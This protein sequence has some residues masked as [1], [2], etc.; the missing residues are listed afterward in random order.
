MFDHPAASAR[1]RPS[2]AES[3]DVP[4]GKRA[5][6]ATARLTRWGIGI[7]TV[8]LL[9]A[10]GPRWACAQLVGRDLP[11]TAY[12]AA[13]SLFYDGE[14]EDALDVFEQQLRGAM[15]VGSSRWIDSICY[16]TMI[17]EC[18]YRMGRF[19]Q[20]LASY[21]A[22]AQLMLAYRDWV[23]H[24]QY[25]PQIQP[26]SLGSTNRR[27][28]W[29]NRTRASVFGEFPDRMGIN[30]GQ[31]IISREQIIRQGGGVVTN[32]HTLVVDV[33]EVMRCS[34]LAIRRRNELLGPLAPHDEVTK[35]L[36][37]YYSSRPGLPNH[38][39][40]CWMDVHLGMALLGAG[41]DSEAVSTLTRGTLAA[42]RFEHPLSGQALLA[43]GNLAMERGDYKSAIVF[44][45]EASIDSVVYPDPGLTEEA[46]QRAA[47]AYMLANPGKTYPALGPA[48]D[49]AKRQRYTTMYASLSLAAADNALQNGDV[50]SASRF[51]SQAQSALARRTAWNSRLGARHQYLS[52]VLAYRTGRYTDGESA[53][54]AALGYMSHG[55]LWLYHLK[56]LQSAYA[57]GQINLRGPIT[58]RAA[59][60]LYARLL[61]TPNG[62]DWDLDPLE[63]LSIAVTPHL[64]AY[65]QWFLIALERKSFEEAIEISDYGRQHR[66][67]TTL[68]LGGRLFSLRRLLESDPATL[69]PTAQQQ[70]Q[71]LLTRYPDYAKL[72][73]QAKALR[74]SLAGVSPVPQSETEA[75]RLLAVLGQLATVGAQQELIIRQMSIERNA[76]ASLFPL[77]VPT[78]EIQARIPEGTAVLAFYQVG[79]DMYGVLMNRTRY[80]TWRVPTT[81]YFARE[82]AALETAMGLIDAN[83]EMN[84]EDLQKSDWK[85]AAKRAAQV[86]LRDSPLDPADEFPELVIVPDGLLWY[87]PFEALPTTAEDDAL[88]WIALHQIRYAPTVSSAV[89]FGRPLPTTGTTGVILGK[90]HP[91]EEAEAPQFAFEKLAA[92]SPQT[93]AVTQEPRTVPSPVLASLF[94]RLIVWDDLQNLDQGVYGWIPAPFSRTPNGNTLDHWLELPWGRPAMMILPG[95]H[96]PAESGLRRLPASLPPGRDMFLSTCALMAGGTQSIVLSRWRNGGRTTV[97][98]IAE[99]LKQQPDMTPSEAFQRSV[100]VAADLPVDPQAEPRVRADPKDPPI[101][102]DHPFFWASLMLLDSGVPPQKE[103]AVPEQ[104]PEMRPAPQGPVNPRP[105]PAAPAVQPQ[106]DGEQV[107]PAQPAEG[108]P[109]E[110]DAQEKPRAGRQRL[111]IENLP[112]LPDPLK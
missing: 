94:N 59:T 22:A 58:P 107:E 109:K 19:D 71:L 100:L 43:L 33:D 104:P 23:L 106:G 7:A 97:E 103:Q 68:P 41:K 74:A 1:S 17:G 87:L 52:A 6:P 50:N 28:P 4:R 34:V 66:F 69:P 67:L 108:A 35:Q 45:Q 9:W 31:S 60:D 84:V 63:A 57:S 62:V 18:Y 47:T 82:I 95:Y 96:T 79:N 27:F 81:A 72:A 73:D 10:I 88:P 112:G 54:Q 11:S 85:A 3:T 78:K 13:F 12:F 14:Y 102:T 49:W 48:L 90:L 92:A 77:V 30:I 38:W 80:A 91:R 89:N 93:V 75:K 32:P 110:P 101:K 111:P 2:N 98:Q 26:L 15:R 21:T 86:L 25:P 56:Q 20:A 5:T 24:V 53:L 42:G 55:G 76:V 99:F 29:A 61:R 39:S 44:Y 65:E 105:A 83:R 37:T 70:R 8:L 40:Q 51:L 36:L 16:Y 64:G 46:L